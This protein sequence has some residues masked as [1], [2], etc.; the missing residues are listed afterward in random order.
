MVTPISIAGHSI[1]QRSVVEQ[2]GTTYLIALRDDSGE[3]VLVVAGRREGFTGGRD[4]AGGALLCPLTPENAAT[5][6][7]RLPWLNPVP[8]GLQ[9]SFGFGDRIGLATPGHVEAVRGTGIAPM[10]AQQS[11][12]EN[13]RIGRTPQQVLD[14]AM[15]GVFQAGWRQPW[16]ADADHVKQVADLAAFVAAGYTFYTIDPSDYVDNAAQTAGATTLSASVAGLPWDMLATRY[17]D[18]ARAYLSRPFQL[19]GLTLTFDEE[20]IHRAAAKYGRALAH[21]ATIARELAALLPRTPLDLELSVDETETPTSLHEHFFIANELQRLAIPVVSL[22]PRFI[23]K[24]QKGVDYIGDVAE[25]ERSLEQHA[26]IMRHFGGYKLSIHTGSDKFSLYPA[27]ARHTGG[28]VHVKTAGTS[29]LEALRVL[30]HDDPALFRAVLDFSRERF[31]QDRKTYFLDCRLELVPPAVELADADLPGLFEQF[32]ARQVLHVTF[33]SVL[34][35][36]GAQLKAWLQ[37]R[38]DAYATA[39]QRHFQRHVMPFSSAMKD[40]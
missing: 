32:D 25:F 5:L 24:F 26:V 11:V 16:G 23:G 17:A 34:E 14:D 18:L 2:D 15:W 13:I 8:L 35:R 3:R 28:R 37:R 29:Y 33:G 38:A 19:D 1:D 22:A 12:R 31:A 6:R 27:I 30:A 9:T 4:D 40:I 10:F 39:L 20:I 36:Y 7:A 21:A